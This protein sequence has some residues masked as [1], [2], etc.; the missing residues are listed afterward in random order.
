MELKESVLGKLNESL[1]LG[2]GVLRY[3]ERLCL[4]NVDDLRTWILEEAHSSHYSIHSGSTKMFH[5]LREVFLSDRLKRVIEKFVAKCPNFQ[6]LKVEHLKSS[7][8]LQEI[9]LP[10]WKREEINMDFV[11]G[12]PQ[13]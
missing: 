2:A 11:V 4:P 10:T 1:T 3:Q 5:D 13:T 12:L 7:G 6:Q 8:L 9:Q